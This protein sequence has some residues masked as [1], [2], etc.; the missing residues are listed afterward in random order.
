MPSLPPRHAAAILLVGLLTLLDGC[1]PGKDQFAPVCP[2][3][4]LLWQAADLNR[5]RD[6][7]AAG[8]KDIRDLILSGRVVAVPAKC[9]AGKTAQELAADVGVTVQLTR[10]PAMQGRATDVQYF[11]A[12]TENGN[13]LDKQ[14]YHS[15]VVFP[16]NVDQVT[17][18]SQVV[19]MVFPVSATKSGAAYTVL[20]GFQLTPEELAYNR[21]HGVGVPR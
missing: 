15:P 9:E 17:L 6:E 12:V 5:Y 18:S 13:I 10:G 21:S 1:G 8:V 16:A 4:T 14:V 19:H 3:A 11:L 20:T 7:S 2:R